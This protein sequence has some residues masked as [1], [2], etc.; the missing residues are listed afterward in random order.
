MVIAGASAGFPFTFFLAF[1]L[2]SLDDDGRFSVVPIL[3][4]S[5]FVFSG[6]TL[7]FLS[8]SAGAD[9]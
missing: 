6:T 2:V 3:D 5:L 7:V 1:S 9:G 8:V 4:F